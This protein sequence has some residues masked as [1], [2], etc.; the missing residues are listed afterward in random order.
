MSC[1]S[2]WG[3][4]R[5]PRKSLQRMKDDGGAVMEM[6]MEIEGT[7]ECGPFFFSSV[8]RTTP[9]NFQPPTNNREKPMKRPAIRFSAGVR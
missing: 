8:M 6:L 4:A 2:K 5:S 9:F 7:R 3:T 1:R